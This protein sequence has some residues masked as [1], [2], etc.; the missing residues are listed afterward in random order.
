MCT[1]AVLEKSATGG[2][3]LKMRKVPQLR[4]EPVWLV[5]R[6]GF[7][8]VFGVRVQGLGSGRLEGLV[9]FLVG[10]RQDFSIKKT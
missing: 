6:R 7:L 3:W 9:F 4:R 2:L 8:L 5:G 1:E 10:V